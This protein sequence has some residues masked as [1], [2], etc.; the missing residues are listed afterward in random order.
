MPNRVAGVL[1]LIAFAAFLV[2][3][4]AA[5]NPFGTTVSRALLAMAATFVIGLVL[6]S[7]GQRMLDE[8]LKD[9]EEKLKNLQ[10]T[11]ATEGR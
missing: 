1:A 11:S 6:G 2:A 5:S 9:Q 10:S 4:M 3:G 8:N 7:M